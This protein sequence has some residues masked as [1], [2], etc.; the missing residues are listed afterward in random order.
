[1]A[2]K[3]I[4]NKIGDLGFHVHIIKEEKKIVK[5]NYLST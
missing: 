2:F 1:M 4:K 5:E 3:K